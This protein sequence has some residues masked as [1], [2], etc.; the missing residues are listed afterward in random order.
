MGP[1]KLSAGKVEAEIKRKIKK[2]AMFHDGGGLW[3][4]VARSGSVSW[5]FR[6]RNPTTGKTRDMGLGVAHMV[7][8][9]EAR[10]KANVQRKLVYDGKDPIIEREKASKSGQTFRQHFDVMEK[11]GP[12]RGW[13]AMLNIHA[14]PVIG[15]RQ[16][17]DISTD[18]IADIISGLLD[19]GK[20][21][22]ARKLQQRIQAVMRSAKG[23]IDTVAHKTYISLKVR[24]FKKARKNKPHPSLVFKE[25]PAFM[26]DLHAHQQSVEIN[27]HDRRHHE[28]RR[29]AALAL[30][31]AILTVCR[32]GDIIGARKQCERD[33]KPPLTW[34]DI[35][36]S[37][38]VWTVPA[39]KTADDHD[40]QPFDIPLS[41][42]AMDVLDRAKA[43]KVKGDERVFAMEQHGMMRE[44]EKLR[45]H[46]TV[47]GMRA[48]FRTWASEATNFERD[49]IET[50]MSHKVFSED[51]AEAAYKGDVTFLP[52]RRKLMQSWGEYAAG[53]S[54]GKLVTL[55]TA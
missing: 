49:V 31:F 41:D 39:I 12:H 44:L 4:R 24:H 17:A 33:R 40:P 18:D 6:Y 25:M 37:R 21:E 13:R 29:I 45:D 43:I 20:H 9:A 10:E 54:R 7:G 16:I 34:N 27:G 23:S 47:H 36:L 19:V 55:K 3:L 38:R 8:L 51:R 53:R 28:V 46:V 1:G 50:A 52:K 42:A 14:M 30:E 15:D 35:N 22:T 5:I 2:P 32:T 48:T 11:R 26:R